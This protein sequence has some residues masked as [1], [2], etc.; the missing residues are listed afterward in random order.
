M[1]EERLEALGMRRALPPPF[2]DDGTDDD[3][4]ARRPPVHV[5]PLRRQVDHLIRR[6][7]HE[8]IARVHDDGALAHGRGAYRDSRE[9]LFGYGHIED[10]G[11]AE[12]FV[13]GAGRAKDPLV[14]IHADSHDEHI[15][16]LRHS[17]N[18]GLG[19]CLRVRARAHDRFR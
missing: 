5:A 10:S 14:I 15:R 17:L 7:K 3:R 9:G 18:Q 16:I 2:P 13:G 12:S 11:P 6:E 4:H 1:P 8:I 19:D